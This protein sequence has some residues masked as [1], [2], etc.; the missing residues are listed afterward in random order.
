MDVDEQPQHNEAFPPP[1][2]FWRL[3]RSD[4]DGS[5]ERPL[6][7]EPPAPVAGTF[8]MFGEL[9]TTEDGMPPLQAQPL[10]SLDAKGL[11]DFRGELRSLNR[12]LVFQFV[13]VLGALVERPQAS[14]R[15]IENIGTILRNMH[16]LLNL[17]RAHQARANLEHTLDVELKDRTSATQELRQN[18]VNMQ[19]AVQQVLTKVQA[20]DASLQDPARGG[21][22]S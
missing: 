5:A 22:G 15:G 6:P 14:T 13:D 21:D 17:L 4:A 20:L 7:P 10:F 8:Q 9:H 18:E 19:E 11:T 12:E 1:P 16:Y 3:Y 2:P